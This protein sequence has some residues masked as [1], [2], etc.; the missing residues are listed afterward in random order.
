M[1]S[2]LDRE[3][4]ARVLGMLGSDHPGEVAAAAGRLNASART[5]V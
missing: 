1:R 5:L 3:R 2:P 4:L